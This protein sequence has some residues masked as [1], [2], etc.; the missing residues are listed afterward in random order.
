[1]R[2]SGSLLA[3]VLLLGLAG[4]P[5]RAHIVSEREVVILRGLPA[6]MLAGMSERPDSLGYVGA[7]HGGWQHAEHQSSGLVG[8]MDACAR[9]DSTGAEAAWS[10]I[11]A[12]MLHQRPGG[13]YEAAGAEAGARQL[14]RTA[15]WI[16]QLCR[17]EVAVMNSPLQDRFRW[18]VALLLP[19]L[20]R[21]VDWLVAAGDELFELHEG[22]PDLLLVDAEAYLLADGIFHEPRMA[23][24]G[25]RS[26]AAGIQGQRKDGAFVAP[27]SDLAAQAR[28]LTG[29]ME[30]ATYFPM[31]SLDEAA[32]RGA[33]WLS[34][35]LS[36]Q[37]RDPSLPAGTWREAL[38]ALAFQSGRANDGGLLGRAERLA[39][40]SKSMARR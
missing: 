29:L 24:L 4:G 9:A 14:E 35:R 28:G 21:S 18:R 8:L 3:V 7:N 23:E 32:K 30:I 31:P 39:I 19:K 15:W 16:A 1:M 2:R 26:L 22:R 38:L 25:Q 37:A 5:A 27:A 36:R 11:E 12:A 13:D 34:R 17:A 6:G 20:R 10:V 40:Q 33:E